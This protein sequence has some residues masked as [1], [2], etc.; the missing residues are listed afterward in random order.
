MGTIERRSLNEFSDDSSV[1]C[2]FYNVIDR[3]NKK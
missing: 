1:Y 2:V 3:K